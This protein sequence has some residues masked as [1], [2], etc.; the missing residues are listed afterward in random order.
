M[1]NEKILYDLAME[2]RRD[3]LREAEKERLIRLVRTK[4]EPQHRLIAH[5]I[6]SLGKTLL[7]WGTSSESSSGARIKIDLLP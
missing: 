7:A 4:T 3:L 5:W 1:Y 2:H 6:I